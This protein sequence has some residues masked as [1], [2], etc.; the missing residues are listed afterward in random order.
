MKIRRLKAHERPAWLEL[1]DGWGLFD[2]WRGAVF[3]ARPFEH[4][5][6]CSDEDVWV[7][8]DEGALVSTLQIFPRRVDL[9]GAAV[10]MG[11]IGSV[12]TRE[13]SRGAGIASA[14][15]HAAVS[16]M[17]DRGMEISL[18]F[19]GRLDFYARLG[20]RS[21]P[22]T[23]ELLRRG[24]AA[25]ELPGDLV[26]SP[27]D[28]ARDLEEVAALHARART[29]LDCVA[30]REPQAWQTSLALAGNPAE[31]FL[32]ARAEASG[33][34]LAYLRAARLTAA[35]TILEHGHADVDALAGLCAGLLGGRTPDPLA[36]QD[37]PSP[38]LRG[39][40]V[41]PFAADAELAAALERCGVTRQAVQDPTP[42]LLCLDAPALAKRLGLER[43][44]GEQ[45]HD[46][47]RRALPPER[48]GYW[49]ADRF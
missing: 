42:M 5:P 10:P 11:G 14:L 43:V 4:D 20:W 22:I 23:R 1:L 13:V 2:G 44:P 36:S 24:E 33:P 27:F 47:L 32:V 46:L 12:F 9:R 38:D 16:D 21:W 45:P 34:V 8:E 48:F 41:L 39:Y 29:S 17:R 25:P 30:L 40:A 31:E 3:F 37:R 18:L 26:I 15:L 28:A 19:S 6:T 49:P 7:A 35:L